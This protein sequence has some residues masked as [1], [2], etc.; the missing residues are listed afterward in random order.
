MKVSKTNYNKEET[1][2]AGSSSIGPGFLDAAEP[3]TPQGGLVSSFMDRIAE[4]VDPMGLPEQSELEEVAKDLTDNIRNVLTSINSKVE[5]GNKSMQ[6]VHQS[7][8]AVAMK[9]QDG[10]LRIKIEVEKALAQLSGSRAS[11]EPSPQDALESPRKLFAESTLVPV[12]SKDDV[13]EIRSAIEHMQS[14]IAA[15]EREDADVLPPSPREQPEPRTRSEKLL[16]DMDRKKPIWREKAAS[17]VTKPMDSYMQQSEKLI[18]LIHAKLKG[19]QKVTN[20]A[21]DVLDSSRSVEMSLPGPK[22]HSKLRIIAQE[23]EPILGDSL[24]SSKI[25]SPRGDQLS[26]H[27]SSIFQDAAEDEERRSELSSLFKFKEEEDDPEI[28]EIP[29]P[30]FEQAFPP[31][32][33]D[34]KLTESNDVPASVGLASSELLSRD[35]ESIYIEKT[36]LERYSPPTIIAVSSDKTQVGSGINQTDQLTSSARSL[37]QT[38][39]ADLS[40]VA[41]GRRDRKR[42]SNLFTLNDV[43][44]AKPMPKSS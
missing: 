10:I 26:E 11:D 14:A 31:P 7:D 25:F 13:R 1:G 38:I 18:S 19:S 33:W 43:S 37:E 4:Y 34:P 42:I 5:S 36:P 6:E 23:I 27:S 40:P 17:S 8:R 9:N 3:V 28:I 24:L 41:S 20:Q 15:F 16:L 21:A 12:S 29:S 30:Q 22:R 32:T 35:D 39:P 2:T 44:V